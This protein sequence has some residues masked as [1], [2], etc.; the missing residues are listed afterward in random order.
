MN[1]RENPA[2]FHLMAKRRSK[3]AHT[4]VA[5][6]ALRDPCAHHNARS[7]LPGAPADRKMRHGVNPAAEHRAA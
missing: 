6:G 3:F 4:N 2:F 5:G 7:R 1:Y